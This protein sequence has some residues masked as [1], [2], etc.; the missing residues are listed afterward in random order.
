[1]VICY[2]HIFVIDTEYLGTWCLLSPYI[3]VTYTEY[4]GWC[5]HFI[6]SLRKSSIGSLDEDTPKIQYLMLL[7]IALSFV[8]L[9]KLSLSGKYW[10]IIAH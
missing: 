7:M 9:Q 3:F 4:L 6:A 10:I 8:G 2:H 1:M 5:I